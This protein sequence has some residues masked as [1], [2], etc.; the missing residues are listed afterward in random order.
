MESDTSIFVT[1][2]R[3]DPR[4]VECWSS[5]A[6]AEALGYTDY[7]NLEAVLATA[8]IACENSGQAIEDHF[9]DIT[10]M[11]EIGR[12]QAGVAAGQSK[13]T[14]KRSPKERTNGWELVETEWAVARTAVSLQTIRQVCPS[15]GSDLHG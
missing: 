10:E 2:R 15:L 1:I 11:I 7:R 6:F 3:I 4:G 8:K 14:L 13:R 5:R 12:S 9:V